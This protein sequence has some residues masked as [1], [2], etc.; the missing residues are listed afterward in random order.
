MRPVLFYENGNAFFQGCGELDVFTVSFDECFDARSE[1]LINCGADGMT[2]F[3]MN[4]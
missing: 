2:G 4:G 3:D 1:C